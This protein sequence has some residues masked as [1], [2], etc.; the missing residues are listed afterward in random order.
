MQ[1]YKEDILAQ[2]MDREDIQPEEVQDKEEEGRCKEAVVVVGEALSWL[3]LT[4]GQDT[5]HP[6]Y[7]LD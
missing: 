4:F 2:Q 6:D 1:D 7:Q 3:S 5:E